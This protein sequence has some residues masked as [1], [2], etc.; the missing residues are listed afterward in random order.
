MHPAPAAA[1]A[2]AGSIT[3]LMIFDQQQAVGVQRVPPQ[4]RHQLLWATVE[5][6]SHMESLP[7][8]TPHLAGGHHRMR[9]AD[10]QLHHQFHI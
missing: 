2:P 10:E 9:G 1:P 4:R 3:R 6:S 8:A 5:R 7:L